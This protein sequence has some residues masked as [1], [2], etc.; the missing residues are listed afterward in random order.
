MERGLHFLVGPKNSTAAGSRSKK[1]DVQRFRRIRRA[2]YRLIAPLVDPLRVL[3]GLRSY[4]G[5]VRDFREYR[6]QTKEPCR[7]IDTWPCLFDK[8]SITTL[9]PHYFYQAAWAF[10]R[11]VSAG[12]RHHVDVG[13]DAHLMACVSAIARVTFI[14][15]RPLNLPLDALHSCKG[16][17]LAL[18]VRDGSVMSIS[19]LHVAE[20]VGLGRYGDSLDAGGTVKACKDLSR[21]LASGGTLY[22]SVPVGRPRVCFNAHR[23]HQAKQIP[24]YFPDLDLVEFSA[25][26]DAGR[27]LEYADVDSVADSDYACGLFRFRKR[28]S[29]R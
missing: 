29:G 9:D 15:L 21:A 27:F 23:I 16:T 4:P 13:S 28:Q 12:C 7:L 8:S 17:V 11:I 19:C 6:R 5:F 22:F 18:P 3:S 24:E 14:D 26:D 20:H 1:L 10:R 2:V 25:V